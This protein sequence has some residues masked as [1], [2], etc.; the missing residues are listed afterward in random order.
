MAESV[1]NKLE[2]QRTVDCGALRGAQA[3]ETVVVNGWVNSVRDHGG[4]TFIDLRDR[5]GVVQIVVDP[6][7]NS[8]SEEAHAEAQKLRSEYC[9][10]IRGKVTARISGAENPNLATGEIEI[11][12]AS[13]EILNPCKTLPFQIDQ[14]QAGTNEELRLKYR[15]LDLRRPSM[16]EKLRLRHEA[17]R[18]IRAFMYE[19]DFIEVETPIL[20]KGTPEGAR[21]YMVPYRLQ[22]GLFYV[23]P[24][25]PQQFKQL[26]MVSGVER[27][28]QIA[29]CFRDEAQRADRQPEFTQLD[30]E[31]SFATQEDVLNLVEELIIKVIEGLSEK[32]VLQPFPRLTYDEAMAR[33]GSDKPDLRFGLELI[34]CA[35]I[36]AGTGFAVFQSILASGGQVK[37]VRYPGGAKLPRREMDE[38]VTLSK[39]FG[40]K[41]FAYF[42]VDDEGKASRGPVA[43]FLSDD[44]KEAI[45]A[46]AQAEPGDLVGF[47]ADSKATTA[48]VLDRLRRLIGEKLGLADKNKLACCWITDFPVFEKDEENGGWTYAHNPFSMPNDGHM[49]LIDT[50]PEAMRAQTYDLVCNGS[51]WASGSVRIHKPDIQTAILKKLGLTD[52][53][54]EA[55]FGH[56]LNA[57]EYGAPPHAGIAP[58][59][60]RLIMFLT[61]DENIREVIAFPKMG[62]GIDPLMNAPAAVEPFQLEELGIKVIE[63]PEKE[64]KTS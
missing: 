51:E 60:D 44:E 24:Q 36:L 23:L 59:V 13:I 22:P 41:G 29:K 2:W 16:Y 26:L 25:A 11:E 15:Y 12:A 7:R 49:D 21:E 5:T 31:M 37:A 48:K 53:Q 64:K 18:M 14:D 30:L 32:Q 55:R 38:L 33:Y 17:V 19:K 58:G 8:T 1:G 34:D 27:Y 52:A 47:I 57:F 35:E 56:M 50:D 45:V 61:D 4:V 6:T 3:G 9:L 54:I 39:E 63:Q 43:K 28:F 42:L 46:A 20:T 62:G 10:S 40:A